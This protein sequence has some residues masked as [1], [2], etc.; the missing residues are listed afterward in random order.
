MN[1]LF[2]IML[3]NLII[4]VG[5]FAYVFRLDRKVRRMGDS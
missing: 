3:V 2:A 1:D 5:V 4:W